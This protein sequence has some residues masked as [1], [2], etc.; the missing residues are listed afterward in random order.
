MIQNWT[1][2]NVPG[3]LPE[4]VQPKLIC[5]F[6]GIHGVRQILLVCK[7]KQESVT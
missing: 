4:T 5:D 3:S 2:L 7:D 6:G 1:D